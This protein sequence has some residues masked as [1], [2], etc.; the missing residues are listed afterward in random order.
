MN[1]DQQRIQELSSLNHGFS[2]QSAEIEELK[3]SLKNYATEKSILLSQVFRNLQFPCA[4]EFKRE[5]KFPIFERSASASSSNAS[6]R[7]ALGVSGN[8]KMEVKNP[9]CGISMISPFKFEAWTYADIDITSDGFFGARSEAEASGDIGITFSD[10]S[11]RYPVSLEISPEEKQ[12]F[13]GLALKMFDKAKNDQQ[14]LRSL[15]QQIDSKAVE[16][17]TSIQRELIGDGTN[18]SRIC[19]LFDKLGLRTPNSEEELICWAFNTASLPPKPTREAPGIPPLVLLPPPPLPPHPGGLCKKALPLPA[20]E[21]RRERVCGVCTRCFLGRC[22]PVPCADCSTQDVEIPHNCGA[23]R[24][25]VEATNSSYRT[26]CGKIENWTNEVDLINQ[27][28]KRKNEELQTQWEQ[29]F[30]T[31]LTEWT[32]LSNRWNKY[33]NPAL[34]LAVANRV[35]NERILRPLDSVATSTIAQHLLD[36]AWQGVDW[37]D[38]TNDFVR[39][40]LP[41]DLSINVQGSARASLTSRAHLLHARPKFKTSATLEISPGGQPSLNLVFSGF[42]NARE[43]G[44]G[45]I[46]GLNVLGYTL[47]AEQVVSIGGKKIQQPEYKIKPENFTDTFD[48]GNIPLSNKEEILYRGSYRYGN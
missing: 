1:E 47:T 32:E 33:R 31:K 23:L 24:R 41:G 43:D 12:A 21:V 44:S 39:T 25:S 37:I 8:V 9:T 20:C 34:A 19:S 26:V 36:A 48:K 27:D 22:G 17:S 15:Q 2:S 30:Q 28:W 38:M 6:A 18:I 40:I 4:P 16:I 46:G 5:V 10:K 13:N 7:A 11:G 3:T 35:V 14:I 42:Q 29:R 45:G